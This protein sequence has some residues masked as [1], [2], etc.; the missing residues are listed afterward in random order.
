MAQVIRTTSTPLGYTL[1]QMHSELYGMYTRMVAGEPVLA[2]DIAN[3][4]SIY[5]RFVS[6]SHSAADLRGIDTFGN[7]ATYGT[8]GTYVTSYSTTPNGFLAQT[9]PSNVTV[10]GE[11][12][13]ADI[14]AI[15]GFINS[16]RAHA[17]TIND[18]TA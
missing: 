9:A 17:H 14:N 10:N 3:L 16:M 11:I 6:H 8:A 12:T 1:T 5:N 15:I 18:I 7:K 2:S 4:V 13:A